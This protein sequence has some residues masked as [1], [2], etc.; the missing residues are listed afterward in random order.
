MNDTKATQVKNFNFNN[1][2]SE[3]TLSHPCISYMTSE[4]LQG[5]EEFHS[6]NYLQEM[7]CSHVKMRLK[8]APQKLNF[9][10]AKAMSKSYTLGCSCKCPCTFLHSYV[11]CLISCMIFEEKYF[12]GY[13]ILTDSIL[14]SG[15]LYFVRYWAICVLT[16]C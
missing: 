8:S 12:S 15:C 13:I 4:R 2:T 14:L 6:K 9:V 16:V 7:P 10:M 1:N 11:S 5:E 3:N